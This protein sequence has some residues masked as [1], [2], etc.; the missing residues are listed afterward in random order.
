MVHNTQYKLCPWVRQ[1]AAA[2]PNIKGRNILRSKN[3]EISESKI[4]HCNGNALSHLATSRPGHPPHE[5]ASGHSQGL[6]DAVWR[7]GET[8][9]ADKIVTECCGALL[10]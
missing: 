3:I 5:E 2:F 8:M 9:K 7:R 4:I 10:R 1:N 6:G